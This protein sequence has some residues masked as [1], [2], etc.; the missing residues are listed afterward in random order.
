MNNYS[1][2]LTYLLTFATSNKLLATGEGSSDRKQFS[3]DVGRRCW[4]AYFWTYDESTGQC[5]LRVETTLAGSE[6]G[7]LLWSVWSWVSELTV[8]LVVPLIIL[9]FNVLVIRELRAVDR[10]SPSS[11]PAW[12]QLACAAD[13]QPMP[14]KRQVPANHCLYHAKCCGNFAASPLVTAKGKGI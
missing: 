10:R 1:H 3:S 12:S 4:Q 5:V 7:S 11:T 13:T 8:F 14:A 6:G 2:L 9:T